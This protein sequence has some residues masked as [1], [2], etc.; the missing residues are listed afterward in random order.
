MSK[1]NKLRIL[2][3]PSELSLVVRLVGFLATLPL[4]L[5][6]FNVHRIV[7]IITPRRARKFGRHLD[8]E[9]VANTC[10]RALNFLARF[11]YPSTCLRRCLLLFHFLRAYGIDVFIHFGA[12][13]S[14]GSLMG[15]SWL[16]LDGELYRDTQAKVSEFTVMFVLPDPGSDPAGT[17]GSPEGTPN[18][19]TIPLDN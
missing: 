3:R 15:H 6:L 19:K 10:V 1:T 14:G 8:E 4:L 16:T 9:R 17:T 5:K 13:T 7:R 2:T 18:F 11:G 12:K